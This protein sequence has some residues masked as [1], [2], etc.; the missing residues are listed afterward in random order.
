MKNDFAVLALM[1]FVTGS[2]VWSQSQTPM[3]TAV[4]KL[5]ADLQKA[6]A[7]SNLTV[8]EKQQLDTDVARLQN[9]ASLRAKGANPDRKAG[10]DAAMDIGKKASSGSFRAEDAE[11]I[12]K[13]LKMLQAAAKD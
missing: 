1:L 2:T 6:S 3:Q 5:Q 10:H 4:M 12:K 13:D 9:N 8:S 7:T 11:L